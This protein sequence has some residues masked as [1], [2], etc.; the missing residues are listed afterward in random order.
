MMLVYCC[1]VYWQHFL[2]ADRSLLVKFTPRWFRLAVYQRHNTSLLINDLIRSLAEHVWSSYLQPVWVDECKRAVRA[3]K[4]VIHHYKKMLFF[5]QDTKICRSMCV[6]K[7]L[8]CCG[9]CGHC[10]WSV[11]CAWVCW[12]SRWR[13]LTHITHRASGRRRCKDAPRL[14]KRDSACTWP[15]TIFY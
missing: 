8:R 4:C 13:P 10:F 1:R 9:V 12:Y 2:M 7:N 5:V 11:A 3:A 15:P 6:W 14:S